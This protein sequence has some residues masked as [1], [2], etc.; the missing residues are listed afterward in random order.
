[1]RG[2]RL[3]SGSQ[4]NISG[5]TFEYARAAIAYTGS[6]INL[7]NVKFSENTLGVSADSASLAYPITASKY[8][9]HQQHRHHQS[10]RVVVK[11]LRVFYFA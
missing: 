3:Y 1:M 9:L 11:L 4:S 7:S 5:A 10:G 2:I 6:P 8:N